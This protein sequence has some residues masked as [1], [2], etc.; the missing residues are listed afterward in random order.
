ML[1]QLYI[2]DAIEKCWKSTFYV[3][4]VRST[5]KSTLKI[6]LKSTLKSIVS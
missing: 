5:L 2:F 6:A 3:T 1:K 4:Y